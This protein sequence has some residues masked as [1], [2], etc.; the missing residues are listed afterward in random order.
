MMCYIETQKNTLLNLR[1]QKN[2]HNGSNAPAIAVNLCLTRWAGQ[3]APSLNGSWQILPIMAF[4]EVGFW[5]EPGLVCIGGW[6]NL[7]FLKCIYSS[8]AQ[9]MHFVCAHQLKCPC[10]CLRGK[11]RGCT[12]QC[13]WWVTLCWYL[14]EMGHLIQMWCSRMEVN[15]E[16]ENRQK[17]F[18]F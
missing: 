5:F 11:S 6:L 14:S 17:L 18:F 8:L 2:T 3:E 7:N 10:S 12:V 16:K 9:L 15:D 1:N 13:H 4:K